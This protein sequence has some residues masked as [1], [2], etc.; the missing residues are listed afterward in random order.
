M[1][2]KLWFGLGVLALCLSAFPSGAEAQ[3]ASTRWKSEP[4]R[5]S[6][7]FTL[8]GCCEAHA[9]NLDDSRGD[10]SYDLDPSVGFGV[11]AERRIMDFIALGGLFE[12]VA[13]KADNGPLFAEYDR[14]FLLDF[15]LFAKVLVEFSLKQ[16][17]GLEL[18][19]LLPFGF[20]VGLADDIP[21][22]DEDVTGFGINLGALGGAMLVFEKFGIFTELGFRHHSLWDEFRNVDYHLGITQ[23]AW[24]FGASVTF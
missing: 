7:Y 16:G 5:V 15:D 18:Y 12:M 1:T 17:M 8:Q 10:F 13:V 21:L 22:V 20:S 23:V 19:G 9:D 24:N 3:S 2:Q 11:R 4:T 6:A 14:D